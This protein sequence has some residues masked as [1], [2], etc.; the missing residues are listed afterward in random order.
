M[1]LGW[2]EDGAEVWGISLHFTD[3]NDNTLVATN[4]FPLPHSMLMDLAMNGFDETRFAEGLAPRLA[5]RAET[6]NDRPPEGED[7]QL[8]MECPTYL[9]P[10]A[11]DGSTADVDNLEYR[12]W[13]SYAATAS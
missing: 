6:F 11:A 9:S 8:M 4:R 5:N 1:L 10:E 3:A 2:S 13:V 7:W 12:R